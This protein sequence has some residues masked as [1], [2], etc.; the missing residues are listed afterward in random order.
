VL[1][2]EAALAPDAPT[3]ASPVFGSQ[4]VHLKFS[5]V[6]AEASV[7]EA[8]RPRLRAW[9]QAHVGDAHAVAGEVER[10]GLLAFCDP[11]EVTVGVVV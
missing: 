7:S 8:G 1:F 6:V 2:A 11:A 5:V 3:P 9:E 4:R 10:L